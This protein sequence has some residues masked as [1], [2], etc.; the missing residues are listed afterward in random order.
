MWKKKQ[1]TPCDVP[2][3]GNLTGE[4]ERPQLNDM[5]TWTAR[6]SLL[7]HSCCGPC[8]TAVIERLAP[9]YDIT[10]FFYNPNITDEEEYRRRRDAQLQFLRCCNEDPAIPWRIGF[11]EGPYDR[12]RFYAVSRGLE[13]EPEG[14]RRCQECFRLRLDKTAET[15]SL[16]GFDLFTTTLTVS[17]HKDY[18]VISS[19][20]RRLAAIY[21]VGFLDLDFKKKNGFQRSVELSRQYGLYRQDYCGCEFAN[22]HLQ[23]QKKGDNQCQ[24]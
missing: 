19:I 11:R 8:S 10:V 14:G 13:R 4:T 12:R 6:P 7:L 1:S 9:D 5:D 17:P 15:A 3:C 16:L 20:G 23:R 21:G 18:R 22:Y 24:T 2:P